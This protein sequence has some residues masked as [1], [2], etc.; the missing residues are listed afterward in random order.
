MAE[1]TVE[2]SKAIKILSLFL[3]EKLEDPIAVLERYSEEEF[4]LNFKIKKYDSAINA[5]TAKLIIDFQNS[6]YRIAA[7]SLHETTN[8]SKLSKADKLKLEI[9]FQISEGSTYGDVVDL[10]KK[11]KELLK[12][13]PEKQRALVL[14]SIAGLIVGYLSWAAYLEYDEKTQGYEVVEKAIDKLA[15]AN[16]EMADIIRDTEKKTLKNLSEMD[17]EVEFQGETFTPD[18]LKEI[19]KKKFPRKQEKEIQTLKGNFIISRIDLKS[20]YLVVEEYLSDATHKIYYDTEDML[21]YMQSLRE[22]L[23]KAIDDETRVFSIEAVMVKKNGKIDTLVLRKIEEKE[24]VV[25]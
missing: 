1:I 23:H 25:R 15:E 8:I 17:D 6:I 14:V 13:I 3:E 2:H 4:T 16:K 12:M 21:S 5:P 22:Q 10:L 11:S 20:N 19:K 18:E 24:K 7:L 9:P